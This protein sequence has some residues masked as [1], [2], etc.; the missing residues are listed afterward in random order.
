MARH[1]GGPGQF[2]MVLEEKT[3]IPGYLRRES[4]ELIMKELVGR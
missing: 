2:E 3:K 4:K 1:D